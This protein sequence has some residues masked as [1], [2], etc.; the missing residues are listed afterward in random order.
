MDELERILLT[1][2]YYSDDE[3]K[4]IIIDSYIE[5]ADAFMRASGVPTTLLNSPSAKGVRTIWAEARDAG[6][7]IDLNGRHKILLSIIEQLRSDYQL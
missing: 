7:D 6:I 2:G 3:Q 4:K 5:E 1:L